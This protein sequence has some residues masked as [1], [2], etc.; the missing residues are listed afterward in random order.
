MNGNERRRMELSHPEM[1]PT[2]EEREE[3]LEI[4]KSIFGTCHGICMAVMILGAIVVAY[5]S[6]RYMG[7]TGL[8]TA[9]FGIL[10]DVIFGALLAY[11]IGK[12]MEKIFTENYISSNNHS[13]N[14]Q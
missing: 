11:Y 2:S 5:T 7:Y 8:Y 12:K 1:F 14:I 6:T 4:S 10:V 13:S 9:F 3:R